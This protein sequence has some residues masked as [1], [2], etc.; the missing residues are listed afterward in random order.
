MTEMWRKNQPQKETEKQR[1]VVVGYAR[2]SA[3][4]QKEDLERQKE[5]LLAY[6][7]TQNVHLYKIFWDIGS[8]MN[9]ERKGLQRMLKTI[10]T[11][12][13]DG[14]VCTYSDRLARFGTTLMSHYCK[15]FGTKIISLSTPLE[16][17]VETQLVDDVLALV[18]SFAGKLHRQRRKKKKKEVMR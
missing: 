17:T 2:V 6:A 12:D 16:Q 5:K 3:P 1:P 9:E 15:T 14:I 4:K 10:T 8:G 11:Q 18:T 7:Q 13:I